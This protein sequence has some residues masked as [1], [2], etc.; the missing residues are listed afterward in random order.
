MNI[1]IIAVMVVCLL[2][3][4]CVSMSGMEKVQYKKLKREL[5]QANLPE[6]KEKDPAT[7]GLLNILPGFG[8]IYLE[9][10]GIFVINLLLWVP[11]ILWGIPQAAIDANTMNKK[12][13]LY[14]YTFGLGKEQLDKAK[15]KKKESD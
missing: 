9:Q 14:H 1:R 6:M 11:S 7:A 13:T 8:N 4:G 2:L 15:D 5:Q 12:E 3:I 10:Y